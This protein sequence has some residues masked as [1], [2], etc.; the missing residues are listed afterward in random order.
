MDRAIPPEIWNKILDLVDFDLLLDMRTSSRY[1]K[2]IAEGHY[3]FSRDIDLDTSDNTLLF[4]RR[5]EAAMTTHGR[6][7]NLN[8]DLS[9]DKDDST[10]DLI[11][12]SDPNREF[13]RAAFISD[14]VTIVLRVQD[15][16]RHLRIIIGEEHFHLL[17]DI[18]QQAAP[19]L[20]S[21]HLSTTGADTPELPG[22][23][24]LGQAPQ[25][26]SLALNDVSF[27]QT[28]AEQ[29]SL[30]SVRSLTYISAD[31][32]HLPLGFGVLVPG[33]KS[34][35]FAASEWTSTELSSVD[36][37]RL[38]FGVALEH[39]TFDFSL[40][41]ENKRLCHLLG[42]GAHLVQEIFM[43]AYSDDESNFDSFKTLVADLKGPVSLTLGLEQYG[44]IEMTVTER[45]DQGRQGR[46]RTLRIDLDAV[47]H[48]VIQNT[49]D[50]ED[51]CDELD[52]VL[53]LLDDLASSK[54][55][56]ELRIN[57]AAGSN[58]I[59][60]CLKRLPEAKALV[61]SAYDGK[62]SDWLQP[63]GIRWQL[64]GGSSNSSDV[65]RLANV[66]LVR[67]V[68]C[69]IADD[70][71]GPRDCDL[72]AV[73]A[74]IQI[75]PRKPLPLEISDGASGAVTE[76]FSALPTIASKVSRID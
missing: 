61:L 34:L 4:A 68:A 52:L 20:E 12:V 50:L 17:R 23:M 41:G 36:D 55:V 59:S 15:I 69:D 29:M 62:Y 8:I 56:T 9:F 30:P 7:L 37:S 43:S 47:I 66:K 51:A 16:V 64:P 33:L 22:Y 57:I 58:F 45:T 46:L 71:A 26:T 2:D 74:L 6:T 40:P 72:D 39:L 1:L 24:F 10:D 49:Y 28:S 5:C 13:Q 76:R 14:V 73:T 18:F 53:G 11:A 42:P 67:V 70:A 48:A 75:M 19:K 63:C 31:K 35:V 27:A 21:F 3:V 44:S 25:L 65:T 54:T 32:L 60:E 38:A